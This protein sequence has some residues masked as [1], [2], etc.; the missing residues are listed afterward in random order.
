MVLT[1][2]DENVLFK[3]A[4]ISFVNKKVTNKILK[5]MYNKENPIVFT[6][7]EAIGSKKGVHAKPI[8]ATRNSKY[9]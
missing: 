2:I 6:K 9:L 8:I 1:N 4:T 7:K 3:T 5:E